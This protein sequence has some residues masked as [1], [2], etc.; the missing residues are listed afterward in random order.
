M[1]VEPYDRTMSAHPTLFEDIDSME[2]DRFARHL[3]DDVSFRFGN[4]DPVTG[5]DAVRDTWGG[6]CDAIAG[7]SHELVEQWN[8]GPATIV[9][10][11]V[12]YTRKDNSTIS[13]PVV[14][15]YRAQGELIEDYRI[16]MD[17][18]PLFAS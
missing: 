4:S 14:T 7:V 8:N 15:I 13:L 11:V 1:T 16:F 17:V 2:A 18:A 10:A 3:S 6:F 9:E 5:R 12:T